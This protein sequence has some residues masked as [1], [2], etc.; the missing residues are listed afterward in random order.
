MKRTL[1][2]L[3][4]GTVLGCLVYAVALSSSCSH[5]G[6]VVD[7]GKECVS[8]ADGIKARD[9]LPE[10]QQVI[11]CSIGDPASIPGCMLS[12]LED[13]AKQFGWSVINC[14]V[15]KIA[16]LLAA[17]DDPAA[18]V[19]QRRAKAWLANPQK[20]VASVYQKE[21]PPPKGPTGAAGGERCIE[22]GPESAALRTLL[23]DELTFDLDMLV[24]DWPAPK[25]AI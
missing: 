20:P 18:G 6:P 11:G 9:I 5:L 17:P 22:L 1:K 25:T 10:V 23:D 19:R 14:A 21:S 16:D 15:A 13:L 2:D 24:I 4:A 7:A 8:E 12:G 3:L